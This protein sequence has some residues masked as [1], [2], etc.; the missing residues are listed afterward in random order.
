[1]H[2]LRGGVDAHR[3]DGGNRDDAAAAPCLEIGGIDPD[4]G[5]FALDRPVEEGL[6][7]DIDLLAQP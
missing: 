4:I 3:N 2:S 6:H 1:M 7:L 5:P